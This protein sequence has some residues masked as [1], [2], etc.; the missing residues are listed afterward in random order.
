MFYLESPTIVAVL[1]AVVACT[2][3]GIVIERLAYAPL[4]SAPALWR[5]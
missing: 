2:V 1:L 3:L 4:R 5:C